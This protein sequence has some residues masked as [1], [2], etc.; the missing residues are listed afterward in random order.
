[1]RRFIVLL[2]ITGTVWA[3]TEFDKLISKAG[4]KYLGEYS[5]LEDRIV[6]FKPKNAL[7]FQAIPLELIESLKLKDGKVII[8]N[9][10]VKSLMKIIEYEKLSIEEKAIYDAKKD[11][12]KW[13]VFPHLA[14]ISSGG[15]GT[16][17]FFIFDDSFDTEEDLFLIPAFIVGSYGLVG[18][19]YLFSIEDKKNIEGTSA[20]DIELY[21]EMYY[22]Q[23]EIQKLK[24]IIISTGA[25]ALIAGAAIFIVFSHMF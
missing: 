20:D 8:K 11:A 25:T 14:L 4:T 5:K 10:N 3:Q 17:T 12:R 6:Y 16:A 18:T 13:L 2:I 15:L 9:G 1:M 24:N 23:F 22:K 7:E 19:Y 21:K